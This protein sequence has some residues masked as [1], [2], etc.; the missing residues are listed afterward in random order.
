MTDPQL[1]TNDEIYFAHMTASCR[2]WDDD[3]FPDIICGLPPSTIATSVADFTNFPN[4]KVRVA[5]CSRHSAE[6]KHGPYADQWS[7]EEVQQ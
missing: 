2:A 1:Q 3:D 6:L 7:Y 4:R 5:F